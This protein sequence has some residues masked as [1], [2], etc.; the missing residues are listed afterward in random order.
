MTGTV[1]PTPSRIPLPPRVGGERELLEAWLDFH[2]DVLLWKCENVAP[3]D[4]VRRT[5]EPSTLTLIGLV[6]HMAEVE[7]T[8]FRRV[9]DQEE[10]LTP[11]YDYSRDR[12]AD[13]HDL[14]PARVEED[15]ATYRAEVERCREV[16]ARH[17]LDAVGSHRGKPVSL[18]W[19]CLHMIE[20]YARHDGHADL[21]R[22]RLDGV[23]GDY[24]R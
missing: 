11:I 21:L 15:L 17:D 4:L 16:A 23:T 19:I 12:D 20:E 14:A 22:E 24:P 7:R 10:G 6:R 3:E 1:S 2:R 9:L 8:W 5:A 13:F 18:R